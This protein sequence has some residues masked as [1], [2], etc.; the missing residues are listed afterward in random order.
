MS[1]VSAAPAAA[2]APGSAHQSAARC[3]ASRPITAEQI[4]LAAHRGDRFISSAA[5]VVAAARRR[6]RAT[7]S[8]QDVSAFRRKLCISTVMELSGDQ[9]ERARR[10]LLEVRDDQRGHVIDHQR[11][12]TRDVVS[13]APKIL[14]TRR[15]A[16][17]ILGGVVARSDRQERRS[18]LRVLQPAGVRALNSDERRPSV[19]FQG[20][21]LAAAR[22]SD[23]HRGAAAERHR[24]HRYR[25][26]SAPSTSAIEPISNAPRSLRHV[27]R[28]LHLH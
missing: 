1:T 17:A 7:W 18:Q 24:R 10:R 6:I 16:S 20:L 4:I 14:D 27:L 19:N 3:C 28:T 23:I 21:C 26:L 12:V 13:G 8:V 9:Y 2:P 22:S 5:V 15:R 25:R 11:R